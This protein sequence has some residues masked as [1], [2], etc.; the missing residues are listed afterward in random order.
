MRQVLYA[1]IILI[2]LSCSDENEQKTGYVFPSF[3]GNG[4]DGLHLLVSY[5][6][7]KWDEVDDY[8]SVYLQEEGLMRDPSICIGGDGKYHMTHTTE[9]F[10]HRIAVTHSGD[11]VNWTPTEFL[12]VWDD[13][14]GIGTEESN[15]SSW[16]GNNL[17]KPVKRDSLVKNCWSPTIFYDDRTKEYVIFWATTIEHPDVFS[18]TWNPEIWENMNHRIYYIVTK[19]FISYTPRKL[20]Y[21]PKNHMVIDAFVAKVDDVNY[22]MGI[23]EETLQQLHVVRSKKKLESWA[24]MPADFWEDISDTEPFAGPNV[25]GVMVRAEGNAIFR[26]GEEW[27]VYCDY[28]KTKSNGAFMTRDFETFTNITERVQ[29]PGWIRNGKIFEVPRSEVDRLSAYKTDGPGIEVEPIPQ[30]SW[31]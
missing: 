11:L 13:Y 28:W 24:N 2:T 20:F 1:F 22:V 18:E 21:A 17:S 27:L 9:W 8:K 26:V 30:A 15:G 3:T 14:K 19:D 25:P 10:D 12:Y 31:R 6:G 23:K 7:F 29:L 5:D 4:E 16:A